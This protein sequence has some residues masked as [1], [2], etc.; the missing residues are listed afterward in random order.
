MV[1]TA[2]LVGLYSD[3]PGSGK[4]AFAKALELDGYVRV[5]FAGTLKSMAAVMLQAVGYDDQLVSELLTVRKEV[6]L[7]ALGGITTRRILQTLGT[8]WGRQLILPE[9]W[10]RCWQG[11]VDRLLAAGQKVV[12]DDVRFT[13]EAEAVVAAGGVML[14]IN[15]PQQHCCGDELTLAHASEGALAGWGFDAEVMNSA[16]LEKLKE[17]ARYLIQALEVG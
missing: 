13:N 3:T 11:Q 16:S 12:A 2:A 5:P 14:R 9:L 8:E 15:R 17:Q 7:D 1:R 4:T 6:P 10:L